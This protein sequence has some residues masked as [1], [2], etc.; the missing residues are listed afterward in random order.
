MSLKKQKN[1]NPLPLLKHLPFHLARFIFPF[2]PLLNVAFPLLMYIYFVY[3][4]NYNS[5]TTSSFLFVLFSWVFLGWNYANFFVCF[6]STCLLNGCCELLWSGVFIL[7]LRLGV[8][9]GL[10][11]AH[12]FLFPLV[13]LVW[14]TCIVNGTITSCLAF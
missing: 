3:N 11:L 12:G 10:A 7:F 14:L 4:V 2:F 6:A 13:I 1:Y 8:V 9:D 5:L